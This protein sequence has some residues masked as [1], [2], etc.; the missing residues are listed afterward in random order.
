LLELLLLFGSG[1]FCYKIISKIQRK[2]PKYHNDIGKALTP[3]PNKLD[4][5]KSERL[6]IN[7]YLKNEIKDHK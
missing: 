7:Q 4:I 1:C 2:N 6:K 5:D 3:V